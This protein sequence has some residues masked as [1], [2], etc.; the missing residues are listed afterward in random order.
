MRRPDR[1][2]AAAVPGFAGLI[3]DHPGTGRTAL[4]ADAY[5]DGYRDGRDVQ[6]RREAEE[7]VAGPYDSIAYDAIVRELEYCHDFGHTDDYTPDEWNDK[8]EELEAAAEH[9]SASVAPVPDDSGPCCTY[10]QQPETT[11]PICRCG[12]FR[13]GHNAP[14]E[15]DISDEAW[16]RIE[17]AIKTLEGR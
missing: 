13:G 16:A 5:A 11:I 17:R 15:A 1:N 12:W 10:E 8:V 9:F 3:T 4:Q 7:R 14:T 2:H 6:A